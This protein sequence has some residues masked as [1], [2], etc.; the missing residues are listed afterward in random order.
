MSLF[1]HIPL[2]KPWLGQEEVEAI[3][4]VV[5]SGW[6]SQGPKVAQFEEAIAS[7]IGAKFAVATN[8]CTSALLLSLRIAGVER[9]DEVICPSFTCMAT[10][11][12]I[13]QLG[14]IPVFA[15]I[16]A[17]T[18]NLDPNSVEA[19]ITERTEA[20]LLVHQIGLPAD[21]E[22]FE[23]LSK[24]YDLP[25]IEDAA[26]ALGATYKGRRLGR[27]G[28]ATSFSFHPRKMITTG[29]GGMLV[30][31]CEAFAERA[32]VLRSAGASISDLVR[33]K[34][35]GVLQQVY[36]DYGYNFRMTDIQAAMG[37][38]QMKKM[39]KIMTQRLEQAKYYDDGFREVDEIIVPFVPDYVTHAYSSYCI[40]I[41][42]SDSSQIDYLV[43]GMADKNISCRRGIQPLHFEPYFETSHR[44]VHLQETES[45]S[46]QTMFLPIFPGLRKEQQDTVISTL[47]DL[48]AIKNQCKR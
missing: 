9:D 6:I 29:E 38:V 21:R 8:A 12:P 1:D 31:N 40:R 27:D 13:C 48:L 42:N 20:I 4:E 44:H 46:K 10:A 45:A 39:D 11:N 24:K 16:D 7:Y 5:L 17:R 23:A 3:Q 2:L 15:D 43:K 26:T 35:K 28:L 34:A 14:A 30:T 22:A 32:R 19:V 33:H 25:I 36:P 41:R 18:Y 37:L 47:K